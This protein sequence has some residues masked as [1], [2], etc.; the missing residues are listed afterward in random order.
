MTMSTWFAWLKNIQNITNYNKIF[1]NDDFGKHL[2]FG[3]YIGH[4]QKSGNQINFQLASK[5]SPSSSPVGAYLHNHA[6]IFNK[7][8]CS[9]S[10]DITNFFTAEINFN[11]S[12]CS[13]FIN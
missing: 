2:G 10:L 12:C 4:W 8:P 13:L 5:K 3:D 6:F 11:F 9:R 1:K 7:I